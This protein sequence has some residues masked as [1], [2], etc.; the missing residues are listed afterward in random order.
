MDGSKLPRRVST[1]YLVTKPS[2][3][4]REHLFWLYAD[5]PDVSQLN[6]DNISFCQ[7]LTGTYSKSYGYI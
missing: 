7:A 4:G 6:P 1:G 3:Q 5:N 2:I